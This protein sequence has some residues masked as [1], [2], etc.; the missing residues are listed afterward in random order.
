MKIL[1]GF[2]TFFFFCFAFSSCFDAPTFGTTPVIEFESIEFVE[3]G[4]FSD[5]DSLNIR[6]K[7]KDGDG[8]LGLG[9]TELDP[10]YHVTNFFVGKDLELIG[11]PAR[12]YTLGNLRFKNLKYSPK[13]ASY[14]LE[15]RYSPPDGK[16]VS[17]PDKPVY[18]LPPFESPYTC[19]AYYQAYLTDTIYVED[20]RLLKNEDVIDTLL[21]ATGN[22]VL[23]AALQNWYIEVNPNHYNIT[24]KF[25]EKINGGYKEF[26][27][28]KEYC[29][30]YDGRFPILTEDKR[31]LEGTLLYAMIGTGFLTT[32]S[33]KTLKVEVTIKDR[34]LNTSNTVPSQDFTLNGIRK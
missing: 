13:K 16:F 3:V 20:R 9:P 31:P 7:F 21:D 24:V 28:R 29:T 26:D 12:L 25:F 14:V 34:A 22:S 6:I 27:F 5:G 30:T 10:P 32:F 15:S 4:D 1:K 17:L 23:Y 19:S 8:D 18:G 11:I 2:A 33:V